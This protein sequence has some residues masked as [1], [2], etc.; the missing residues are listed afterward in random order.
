MN[1]AASPALSL[2]DDARHLASAVLQPDGAAFDWPAVRTLLQADGDARLILR[3]V[4]NAGNAALKQRFLTGETA[5][6]PSR[7]RTFSASGVRSAC[8]GRRS[9]APMDDGSAWPAIST[10]CHG[11]G[12]PPL[13]GPIRAPLAGIAWSSWPPRTA[14]T[15][16][17]TS[18]SIRAWTAI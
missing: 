16:S 2:T 4:L 13:D 6:L 15:V 10:C 3:H 17:S 5:A 8:P 7:P 9:S 12:A 18:T 11:D 14:S 1:A